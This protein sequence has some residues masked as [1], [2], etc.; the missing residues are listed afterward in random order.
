MG[1]LL[2]PG[3]QSDDS[4]IF[5]WGV[6][7]F[8]Y[9]LIVAAAIQ[10]Y[11]IP[12]LFPHLNLGD[13]LTILDA[14]L[15]NGIAKVQAAAIMA[16]GWG[17]WELR[18]QGQSPAGIA[19]IFYVLW[20]PKP[21]SLLPFNALVHALSG[22]LVLWILRHFFSWKAAI[23]GSALFVVNPA[24]MEWVAQIHRDGIFILGNLLVLV[25][26][27]QLGKGLKLAKT[28]SIVWGLACGLIGVTLAWVARSY[29]AQVLLVMFFVCACLIGV[30]AW[31][32]RR[33][34]GEAE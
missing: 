34:P 28:R 17:V 26:L 23:F 29:W 27:I 24:A 33:Q 21:Y 13:G 1:N 3:L 11:V 14:P 30:Y 32:T 16:Q 25:C 12:S 18:P 8:I 9:T 20:D 19:S 4:I 15:F 22:C 5:K 31:I 2:N 6:V 10:L 7:F